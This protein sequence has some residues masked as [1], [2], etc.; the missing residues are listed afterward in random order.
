M[1]KKIAALVAFGVIFSGCSQHKPASVV[2]MPEP[3]SMNDFISC[4]G[5]RVYFDYDKPKTPHVQDLNSKAMEDLCK[6]AE[7]LK[8]YE[9]YKIKIVGHC[10]ERGTAEYN[11]GLGHRRASA[12][13]TYLVTQGIAEYRITTD[14]VG[15][16]N[17]I[18]EGSNEESWSKNRCAVLLLQDAD[19]K[20][21]AQ[22]AG[23]KELVISPATA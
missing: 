11:M 3:G 4:V 15:K 20:F 18:S 14:S 2:D 17:P 16:D 5:D 13:K 10:D 22:P 8:R 12:A 21:I 1:N 7:W 23:Q 9:N 6:Q 19:G